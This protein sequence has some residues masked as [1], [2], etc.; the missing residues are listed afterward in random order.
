[1]D[2]IAAFLNDYVHDP[3]ALRMGLT[4]TVAI[5]VFLL[6]VGVSY[7][8]F[9][10]FSPA[11]MRLRQVVGR[12]ADNGPSVAARI[13]ERLEPLT[14]YLLPKKE[15]ERTRI[16]AQLVHAGFRSRQ[17]LTLFYTIKTVFGI[18]L[19]IIVI[20]GAPFVGQLAGN[21]YSLMQIV[22][23]ALF[24]S[25]VGMAVPN[26]VLNRLVE[27]RQRRIRKGFPDALDMLVVA[28][29]AGIGL[30][31]AIQRVSS[32]LRHSHPALANELGLVNAEIR[33]GI[34]RGEALRNLARRTGVEDIKIF[35]GMIAQTL[36]YG[37]SIA[38]TLRIFSDDFRDKRL[39]QAEEQAAKIGTK[40]IFPMAFCFFPAFFVV[41]LGPAAIKI[42]EVFGRMTY[43]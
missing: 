41:A 23:A 5:G 30:A 16:D 34:D 13:G 31:A 37:T 42:I 33:S 29:E 3:E 12:P 9:T 11:R 40:M 39:Q 6:I 1:M 14:P 28:M 19:A 35:A 43:E 15:W 24:A 27:R 21:Q 18:L 26:F 22:M 20:I 25:L 2:R 38:D 7:V 17:A 36:R 4:A 32:E 8:L 10:T